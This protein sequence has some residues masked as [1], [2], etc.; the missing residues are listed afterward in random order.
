MG[1]LGANLSRFGGV[2][3]SLGRLGNA[4]DDSWGHLGG[5]REALEAFW[6]C[7]GGRFVCFLEV[8][9]RYIE[10]VLEVDLEF[11]EVF[12]CRLG[13]RRGLM[14]LVIWFGG[15]L[16]VSWRSWLPGSEVHGCKVSW[17]N[18]DPQTF[19]LS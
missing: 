13:A 2:L 18:S 8:I 6:G 14:R 3:G 7:L 10:T 1:K 19:R 4:L 17:L 11:V 9:L 15:F 5:S 12:G 16:G